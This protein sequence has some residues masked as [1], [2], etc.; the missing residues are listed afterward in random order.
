MERMG[1]KMKVVRVRVFKRL[2]YLLRG[3][4]GGEGKVR[5][6]RFGQEKATLKNHCLSSKELFVGVHF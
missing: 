5:R 6:G 4:G 2:G 3:A 1:R